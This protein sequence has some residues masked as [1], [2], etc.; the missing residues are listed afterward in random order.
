MIKRLQDYLSEKD[1]DEA[2]DDLDD[3][4]KA[5]LSSMQEIVWFKGY[6]VI[7]DYRAS[8][9]EIAKQRIRTMKTIDD[10]VE[11]QARYSIAQDFFNYLEYME[12]V[13]Q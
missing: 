11:V 6:T 10:L 12:S 4:L 8:Q 7:K 3:E 13:R 2:L 5:K 1:Y 9:V